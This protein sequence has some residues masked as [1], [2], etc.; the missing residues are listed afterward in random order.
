MGRLSKPQRFGMPAGTPEC[1]CADWPDFLRQD[2]SW[3]KAFVGEKT[4]HAEYDRPGK[5][6]PAPSITEELSAMYQLGRWLG[7]WTNAQVA[8][9]DVDREEL[10]IKALSSNERPFSAFVYR[11]R[12]PEKPLGSMLLVSGLHFLGPLDPRMDRFARILAHAGLLVL[13]PRL[14]DF[15][16]LILDQR[17]F[18]DTLRAW[19]TL[20]NLPDKP[21]GRSGVFS[22][23]F[24]SLPSLWLASTSPAARDVGSLVVFGGYADF[25]DTLRFCLEG[26]TG[27]AHDP[28]NRPV[29]FM[30][31][32]PYLDGR[33]DEPTE[34]FSALR[35][36][37]EATW[38]K[39][40]M[41]VD[42]RWQAVARDVGKRLPESLLPL[43]FAA[44]G[45]ESNTRALVDAAID[46]AGDSFSWLN[47]KP[48]LGQVQCPVDL[49]HGADDD[50]IP[51]EHAHALARGLPP[52]FLRGVHITG[53]YGHTH[54]T[55]NTT[56]TYRDIPAMAKEGLT[57][58]RMLI[59]I[60]RS[61]SR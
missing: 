57:M 58:L 59:A 10:P 55:T 38:G 60:T 56:M 4:T 12:R 37:V 21:R 47:P 34:L 1:C 24:G 8:P 6:M 9:N 42:G 14:P 25:T 11:A 15:T 53:L 29:V 30:N 46:R 18:E 35:T 41:K 19:K 26:R 28:L 43:Y 45:L 40:E 48:F 17:V 52:H 32:M 20:Q 50:V 36:Y 27:A 5:S 61:G 54:K 39:P 16:S 33:P 44:T 22:I 23:S 3:K 2:V 49:I 7:P 51:Y 31:L 13:A